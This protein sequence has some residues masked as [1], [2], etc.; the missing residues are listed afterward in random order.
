MKIEDCSIH[1]SARTAA[2]F[3]LTGI[4]ALL[5]G[6]GSANAEP[7]ISEFQAA[8]SDGIRDED[9]DR[10][11]WIEIFN[12]ESDTVDLGGM[13]LTNDPQ[14]RTK[15]VLPGVTL[16]PN[17][18]LLIWA[19]GKNRNNP[20]AA[21]HTNFRL[22][23]SGEY[24]ALMDK[25][26]VTSLSSF[27]PYPAQPDN[28]SYGMAKSM[29]TEHVVTADTICRWLV[30]SGDIP[31]WMQ[32]GFDDGSWNSAPLEI[33]YDQQADGVDFNPL[34]S[35][36]GNIE[37]AIYGNNTTCYVRIPFTVTD[38][39][40]VV[41]LLL[42]FKYDDGCAFYLNGTRVD[43]PAEDETGAPEVLRY[44]SAATERRA[45]VDAM[46]AREFDLLKNRSL[47]VEGSN[48]LAIQLLNSDKYSPDALL[49]A[50]LDIGR[51]NANASTETGFYAAPTP[52][53]YNAVPP[54]AGFVAEP[55]FSR[56]RGFFTDPIT[57]TLASA[58]PDALIRYTLDG[59]M[60]TR[61]NGIP[62]TGP[63]SISSTVALHA[64]AFR[65][66][67][68]ASQVVSH[69]YI[70]PSQVISQTAPP[71][72]PTTWGWAYDP[73]T[74]LYQPA[75]NVTA[76]YQMDAG[77]TRS[78]KYG[79][80]MMD[81]LKNSLPVVSL[82]ASSDAI[83][84]VNGIYSNGRVDHA[85]IP[86]S[87][88][89]FDPAKGQAFYE[90]AGLRIH[91]GNAASEHPKKP[92]RVYFRKQYG[93]TGE[94]NYPLYP[95][96]PVTKFDKLQL[97]PGGHDGWSVPFGSDDNSLARHATYLRDRFLRQTELDMGR[98]SSRGSYVHLYLN[99]LY[100]GVYDLHEVP[101]SDFYA[102]HVGDKKD[103]W[104]ALEHSSEDEIP[105]HVVD[106]NG[107][108]L[109]AAL[110]L[111]RPAS[112]M[113]S[114]STYG[115]IGQLLNIDDFIDY[116][117]VQMWAGNNDWVGPVFR[118]TGSQNASRYSNKNWQMGIRSRATVPG[119]FLWNVWDGE[120]SMGS[121]VSAY[122]D[123]MRVLDYNH[124]RIGQPYSESGVHLV[125]GP[126]GELYH[127]LQSN[128]RFRTRFADRLQK[129]LFNGGVLTTANSIA[130]ITALQNQLN[131]PIV[132][133]SAR[134][135][136]VNSGNP[137]VV[138]FLRDEHWL[139]EVNWLK[140]TYITQRTGI[141]L[142]QFHAIGIWPQLAAPTMTPFG[143]NIQAGGSVVLGAASGAE[144]YYTTDGSDP[145]ADGVK[146]AT[147][148]KY[149]G[150][151]TLDHVAHL[152]A[153]SFAGTE[154]SP[155]VEAD[156]TTAGAAPPKL[157][158]TEIYYNPTLRLGESA[159]GF[160]AQ[161]FEFLEIMNAG[162]Q[163]VPLIG[164]HF[165]SGI[166][167]TF[168]SALD[169][170][171][172]QRII[173]VSN[174]A[175]FAFRNPAIPFA[176]VFQE[177]S[178]LSNS[179]ERLAMEDATGRPLFDF[180]YHDVSPWPVAADGGGASMVL[181]RPA[182]LPDPAVPQNWR[183]SLTPGGTPGSSDAD[184]Y[185]AWAARNS[186]QGRPADTDSRGI[187]NLFDYALGLLPGTNSRFSV[188]VETVSVNSVSTRYL[189]VRF[190]SNTLAEDVRILPEYSTDLIHWSAISDLITLPVNNSDGTQSVAYRLPE[191]SGTSQAR[192]FV[193]IRGVL[194]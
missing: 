128:R 82:S 21:L 75:E 190:R 110:N 121:G 99:G 84:G 108:K 32:P 94:L 138:T 139:D 68:A 182:D 13:S 165:T 112:A 163:K 157:V 37:S 87:I 113:E 89:Y 109:D 106:G 187:P 171:P 41:S 95:D 155:L 58:T 149:T 184:S 166:K 79:P 38:P 92:F 178:N 136:N 59:S 148:I 40:G 125:P 42:R 177:D 48:V 158:V 117:I 56:T 49:V 28:R 120:I 174:G 1:R 26:E 111:C 22:G 164:S 100:W 35:S 119:K 66:G 137:E 61:T 15:W 27:D 98:L 45:D 78:G 105:Y 24:L 65:R 118:G 146:T 104:D 173:L 9:G 97:R 43:V 64:L 96:S 4:A 14:Q 169:L 185:T 53:F 131:S 170:G 90:N 74:E 52:G 160:T 57:V 73:G 88:E 181:I 91:G 8:N 18:S 7:F 60:P 188:A 44:D 115:Q 54:V 135:G 193:R 133:E 16:A 159:V 156:F 123:E 55:S 143:G 150:S 76:D 102:D 141:L 167:F 147:A 129:H 83:F 116:L 130:R 11:D 192:A 33:G 30:P 191:S 168:N 12:P 122:V 6:A 194:Y 72:L 154:W 80:L 62:Y 189:V 124:T 31:D 179:G 2:I 103:E 172:G 152:S 145:M 71:D 132:A 34:I 5:L 39:A 69:T 3:F 63:V 85:E 17:Q 175:A 51:P 142:G 151:L 127:A 67:W 101:D 180:T 81:A 176:G 10:S 19:S 70:F 153:R 36:G 183:A 107:A 161:Q 46:T 77:V 20:S 126:P 114:D 144:I 162:P 140:N 25:D 29:L 23:A 93:G 186:I 134:W 86:V 47:L 50:E